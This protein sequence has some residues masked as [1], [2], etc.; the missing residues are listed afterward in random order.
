MKAAAKAAVL[1]R[2]MR[3]ARKAKQAALAK[4]V[5]AVTSLVG[6]GGEVEA[7]PT[8][9][10]KVAT[11]GESEVGHLTPLTLKKPA[12]VVATPSAVNPKPKTQNPKP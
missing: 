1:S 12:A 3:V 11:F 6:G 5:T 7:A 2:K 8:V 4:E 9:V 10:A